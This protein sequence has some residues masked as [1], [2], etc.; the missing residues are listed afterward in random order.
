MMVKNKCLEINRQQVV[1]SRT[2]N[3]A[4]QCLNSNSFLV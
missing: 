4:G 1:E 2:L 3:E